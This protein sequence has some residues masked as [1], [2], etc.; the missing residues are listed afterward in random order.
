MDEILKMLFES[1]FNQNSPV[2]RIETVKD[3]C[4]AVWDSSKVACVFAAI[5]GGGEYR[6]HYRTAMILKIA[7]EA[8]QEVRTNA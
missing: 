2:E 5:N 8:Y 6:D 1:M 4:N 3:L 7:D